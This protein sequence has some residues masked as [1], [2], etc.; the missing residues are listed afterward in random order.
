MTLNPCK[1]CGETPSLENGNLFG[2]DI[3]L[4]HCVVCDPHNLRGIHFVANTEKEVMLLWN[5]AQAKYNG[6]KPCPFCG[7]PAESLN[8]KPN[9][10]FRYGNWARISCVNQDCGVQPFAVQSETSEIQALCNLKRDVAGQWN[11]RKEPTS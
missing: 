5:A 6:L 8:S 10:I 3:S 2:C 1:K 7:E 4:I 11:T 9:D